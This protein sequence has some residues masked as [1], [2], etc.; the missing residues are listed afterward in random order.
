MRALFSLSIV[1]ML[2]AALPPSIWPPAMPAPQLA[3]GGWGS[4]RKDAK[5]SA[6]AGLGYAGRGGW[7][8]VLGTVLR[9][10]S[11]GRCGRAEARETRVME[12]WRR[13]ESGGGELERTETGRGAG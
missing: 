9:V 1:A 12:Q 3:R 8:V 5:R 10:Q 11:T 4:G 2:C 13:H 6:L 7:S